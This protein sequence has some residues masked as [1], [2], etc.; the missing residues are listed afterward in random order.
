MLLSVVYVV[1]LRRALCT[2]EPLSDFFVKY[3]SR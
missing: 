3:G 2:K 1:F